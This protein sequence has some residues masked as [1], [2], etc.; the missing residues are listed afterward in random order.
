[1]RRLLI[2]CLLALTLLVGVGCGPSKAWKEYYNLWESHAEEWDDANA[3]AN[4]ASR[5]SLAGPVGELQNLRR[6]WKSIEAPEGLEKFHSLVLDYEEEV[7]KGYL[8]FMT[9]EPDDVVDAHFAKARN[10]LKVV[11]LAFPEGFF[12][13]V[14]E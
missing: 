7:I 11:P 13:V 1:M 9:K 12:K 3:I 5:I 8:A 14:G 4:S 2:G 6:E 10:Y